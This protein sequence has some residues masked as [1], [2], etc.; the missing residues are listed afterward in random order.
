MLLEKRATSLS[1]NRSRG[2]RRCVPI[3]IPADATVADR[4]GLVAK[5]I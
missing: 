5:T 3:T 4:L 2:G 1:S